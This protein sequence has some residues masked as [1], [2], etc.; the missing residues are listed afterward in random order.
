M[1]KKHQNARVRK[2]R[3]AYKNTTLLILSIFVFLLLAETPAVLLV[4]EH[5]RS[6]GYFGAGIAGLL[7]VSTFTIAPGT[8]LL[9]HLAEELDPYKI[10]LYAGIGAVI[11]DLLIFRFF[12]GTVFKELAP[13]VR[14]HGG[15]QLRALACSP[16]FTWFMPVLGALII[17]LPLLPDELGVGLMGLTKVKEWQFILITY[18]LNVA[19]VLVIVLAAQAL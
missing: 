16:H 15:T 14:K 5:A 3:W 13:L 7:F 18:V 9:F 17:A 8:A 1:T 12:K 11:G 2:R 6:L 10:A 4:L 19:G